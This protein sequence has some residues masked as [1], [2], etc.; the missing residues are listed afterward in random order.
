V[1]NGSFQMFSGGDLDFIWYDF[2]PNRSPHVAADAGFRGSDQA[3]LSMQLVNRDYSVG[4][5]YP[6]VSSYPLN[7]RISGHLDFQTRIVFFHG[8]QKPWQPSTHAL[9]P[10]VARRWDEYRSRPNAYST[11]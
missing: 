5:S 11:L 10:W 4:L 3:W 8:S 7:N 9:S 1:F 6:D 2:N